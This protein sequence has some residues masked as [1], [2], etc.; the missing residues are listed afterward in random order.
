MEI[1]FSYVEAYH[2]NL[3][4]I[5]EILIE[6]IILTFGFNHSTLKKNRS[7]LQNIEG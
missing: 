1:K 4:L 3:E 2:E 5:G 6:K 7:Y